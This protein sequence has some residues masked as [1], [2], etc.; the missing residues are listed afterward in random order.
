VWRA[1]RRPRP[2]R[3]NWIGEGA[4]EE[5]EAITPRIS[6]FRRAP[7]TIVKAV[8]IKTIWEEEQDEDA[9]VVGAFVHQKQ[10]VLS[11]SE[12]LFQNRVMV[13]R[14]SARRAAKIGHCADAPI[15]NCEADQ[16]EAN[17]PRRKP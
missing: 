17:I 2:V 6:A 13:T 9:Y 8:S 14:N 11:T 12:W 15:L 1:N 7:V 5:E 3:E 10:A 4:H 16:P